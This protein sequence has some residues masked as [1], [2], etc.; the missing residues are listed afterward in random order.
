MI[1]TKRVRIWIVLCC[2]CAPSF[3]LGAEDLNL[4]YEL[5]TNNVLFKVRIHSQSQ[6]VRAMGSVGTLQHRPLVQGHAL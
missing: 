2:L 4:F 1:S 5:Y 3:C 6:A